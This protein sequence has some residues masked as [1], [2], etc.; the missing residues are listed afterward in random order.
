[1]RILLL[2]FLASCSSTKIVK[3]DYVVKTTDG[4]FLC[5]EYNHGPYGAAAKNCEHIL[6]DYYVD[7]I[8]N[9]VSVVE[10]VEWNVAKLRGLF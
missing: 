4:S 7:L 1:M 9:P 3:Y 8:P 2:V 5:D 10:V 6:L